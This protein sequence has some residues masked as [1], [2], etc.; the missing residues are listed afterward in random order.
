MLVRKNRHFFVD[1]IFIF[2]IITTIKSHLWDNTV[3]IIKPERNKQGGFSNGLVFI[4]SSAYNTL[5]MLN[6]KKLVK[7][8]VEENER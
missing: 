7:R 4:S 2:V 1:K 5:G 8:K 6:V 3:G